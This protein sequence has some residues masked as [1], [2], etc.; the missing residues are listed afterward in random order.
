M[1]KRPPQ[2]KAAVKQKPAA[3]NP[4]IQVISS[5]LVYKGP[6][7]RAFTDYVREGDYTGRRD[8]IRHPGSVVILAVDDTGLEPQVLL[9]RQ[10]RYPADRYLWELPAGRVDPG[11]KLL[12][13]AKRE[14]L[15]ET[16]V[17]AKSWKKALRF[18]ASPG[19]LDETMNIFLAR[20]LTLGEAQPE[21]YEQISIRWFPLKQA[22]AMA[23]KGLIPDAKTM[24]ALYWLLRHSQAGAGVAV[25]RAI[26][27]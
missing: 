11:E 13:A 21:E 27:S 6:V 9:C 10:Y 20:G 22:L 4:R 8:V 2:K 26:E 12:S 1:S 16:G 18:Y 17:T 25:T 14:L 3:R 23:D 19:F 7:F 24:L 15:E 5:K